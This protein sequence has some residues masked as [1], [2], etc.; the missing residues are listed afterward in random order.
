MKKFLIVIAAA[1]AVFVISGCASVRT[2]S[3]TSQFV[4]TGTVTME[5]RGEASNTVWFL[6]FGEEN[7]PSI[8]RVA[9]E[10]GINRIATVEFY[11]KTGIFGLWTVFT[12][13]VTGEGPGAD[14]EQ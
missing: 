14:Q 7:Y 5:I 1:L 2:S 8:E 3:A 4:S 9:K 10:N 11:T 6:F 13:I 12:T